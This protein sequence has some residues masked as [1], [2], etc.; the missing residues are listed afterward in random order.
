MWNYG[1]A[2]N[3]E[4]L[5][6]DVHV[7]VSTIYGYR[8]CM[9]LDLYASVS[10]FE[11]EVHRIISLIECKNLL[12]C[13][14]QRCKAKRPTNLLIQMRIQS[15]DFTIRRT[16]WHSCAVVMNCS[17]HLYIC[18]TLLMDPQVS[19]SRA[20]IFTIDSTIADVQ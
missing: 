19:F 14:D 17:T 10:H 6:S 1:S 20:L 11:S 18:S 9:S 15:W 13:L 16:F 5:L 12:F 3:I 2:G 8:R 4:L 7:L